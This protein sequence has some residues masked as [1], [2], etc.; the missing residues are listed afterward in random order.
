MHEL[1]GLPSYDLRADGL[2][3]QSYVRYCG[4]NGDVE[5]RGEWRVARPLPPAEVQALQAA[6][7]TAG[8]GEDRRLLEAVHDGW[9]AQNAVRLMTAKSSVEHYAIAAALGWPAH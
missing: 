4:R 7:A 1:S 5:M 8:P 6:L 2:Y 3:A 9:S